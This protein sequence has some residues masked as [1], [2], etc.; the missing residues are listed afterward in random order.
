MDEL[1]T[2]DSACGPS[3][4][5]MRRQDSGYASMS[6]REPPST[7]RRRR[8]STTSSRN[9]PSTQRAPHSGTVTRL[10]HTSKIGNRPQLL[11]RSNLVTVA[12]SVYGYPDSSSPYSSPVN[13]PVS[14]FHFPPPRLHMPDDSSAIQGADE[15]GFEQQQQQQQDGGFFDENA[16]APYHLP[17]QTTHY[18]TSDRTRRLEYAAIDAASRGFKGWMMRHMVPDCFVPKGKRRVTFD[19]DTGSVRRY[20][21]ALESEESAEKDGEAGHIPKKGRPGAWR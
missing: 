11:S 16:V 8:S 15:P 6:S 12:P 4:L 1:A 21:I 5:E 14:Y 7:G 3:S 9:R 20:R 17:P 2:P 13:A 18:W 19:D 10:P